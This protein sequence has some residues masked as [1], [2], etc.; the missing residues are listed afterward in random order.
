MKGTLK[1]RTLDTECEGMR[2]VLD[3]MTVALS[4]LVKEE[5]L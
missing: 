2:A 4:R 1:T 3:A 5:R